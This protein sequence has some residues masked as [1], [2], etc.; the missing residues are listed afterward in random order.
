MFF[1]NSKV[2]DEEIAKLKL[3]VENLT[4]QTEQKEK[5]V[6]RLQNELLTINKSEL[7]LLTLENKQMK[8]IASLSQE[9][10]LVVFKKDGTI[11]FSNDKAK[12]SIKSNNVAFLFKAVTNGENKI[13]LEDCEAS[14]VTKKIDDLHVV[15]LRKTSIHDNKDNGL[16]TRH[17]EN[18]NHSLS[19]TQK[20]YLSLLD[21]LTEMMTE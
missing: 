13:I 12:E 8:Q 18:I 5:E 14:M 3:Q 11:F 20:V 9:E 10:G 16:L 1:G 17:N 21:D 6:S 19:D 4:A 7:E 15:S 2:K